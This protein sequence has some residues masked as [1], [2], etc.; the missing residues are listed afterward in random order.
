M[1]KFLK[2]I[3]K[4]LI[5]GIGG[6][7]D[8]VGTIPMKS[9]LEDH[10]IECFLGGL[11]WERYSIDPYPGPRRFNEIQKKRN[12]NQSI[13]FINHKT[14]TKDG[15]QFS[16]SKVAN[17]VKNKIIFIN[18]FNS[19]RNIAADLIEF[20]NYK[21][22]DYVV[23]VDVG[24]DV[25]AVGDEKGLASPLADSIMLNVLKIIEMKCLTHLG[26]LGYGS[27]GELKISEI[28]KCMAIASSKKGLVGSVGLSIDAYETMKE[29]VK[30]V[31]TDAS[32]IPLLSFEG[33]YGKHPIRRGRIQVE[34]HPMSQIT[35]LF[36]PTVV[37]KNLS[38][39]AQLISKS[40]S[41]YQANEILL[42]NSISSEFN[43]EVKK[44][45]EITSLNNKE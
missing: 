39:S 2:K 40:K 36:S 30:K 10:G 38:K 15:L 6:G 32:R 44:H 19:I 29:I 1:S 33:S 5:I 35:F 22:I 11:P 9:Y 4:A 23:G 24:G 3:K 28:N 26:V 37:F 17:F 34:V 8:I 16:E 45:M 31:E 43:Y 21:K 13:C 20:I 7:A 41:F 18:I 27:D 14:I 12:F 25:L 42:K